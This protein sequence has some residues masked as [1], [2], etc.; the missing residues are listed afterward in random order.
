[1]DVTTGFISTAWKYVSVLN[2]KDNAPTNLWEVQWP[3]GW[4]LG[5]QIKQSGFEPWLRHC[6]VLLGKTL[7]TISTGRSSGGCK[8]ESY[9]RNTHGTKI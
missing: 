1:M 4:C 6:V 3:N 2:F 9:Q 7:K 8:S 5:L